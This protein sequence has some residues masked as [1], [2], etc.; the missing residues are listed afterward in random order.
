LRIKVREK[1]WAKEKDRVKK[2]LN[3][4]FGKMKTP[5]S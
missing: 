2:R 5:V 3:F 1:I 4:F